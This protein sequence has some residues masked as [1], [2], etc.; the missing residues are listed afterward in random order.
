MINWHKVKTLM[1]LFPHNVPDWTPFF[2]AQIIYLFIY[3]YNL[4]L[5]FC[6][7]PKYVEKKKMQPTPL[8]WVFFSVRL[9]SVRF[10]FDFGS[11]HFYKWIERYPVRFLRWKINK[12]TFTTSDFRPH[13]C[14]S[15]EDPQHGTWLDPTRPDS[16]WLES[17]LYLF[18]N[19][20]SK[21]N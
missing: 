18:C 4:Q 17:G 11:E 20:F 21:N 5:H 14:P 7:S 19:N 3:L 2:F 1:F 10:W 13:F 8:I 9:G 6:L 16:T 12:I 15:N